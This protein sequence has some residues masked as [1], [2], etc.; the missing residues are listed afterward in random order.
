MKYSKKISILLLLVGCLSFAQAQ[1]YKANDPIAVNQKIK[2]GILPNGMTYY[3]YPT[4]VNKNTASYYIIQNVGSILEND[5]QKGLA[6]FLEHM[7]FNGTKHFEG[8]GILNTLQKQGAI[9][10]KNI[11]A[12]TS[13]DETVY[14]LDNIP[15]KEEGV[16]DTC[17]LVLH[18]WSNFLSLTN[19]EID[20]ERG[21]ITEEWRTRQNAGARI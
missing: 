17:L 8:K 11:N 5:Q 14:N 15:S 3:I 19:E 7:A 21:V 10:G 1:Q 6:H 9:F 12:Y 16:I 18:D 2:K 20:A 13:T 4:E